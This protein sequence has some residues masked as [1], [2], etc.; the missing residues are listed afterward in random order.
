[1]LQK[2]QQN[3]VQLF[4][5]K[6]RCMFAFLAYMYYIYLVYLHTYMLVYPRNL[7]VD[8]NWR[9]SICIISKLAYFIYLE[10]KYMYI[11]TVTYMP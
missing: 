2:K 3:Y 5:F 4:L 11:H 1:M 7:H 9:Y 8:C 6:L 10:T